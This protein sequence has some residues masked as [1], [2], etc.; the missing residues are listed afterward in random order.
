MTTMARFL[1]LPIEVIEIILDHLFGERAAPT[2]H[3]GRP[4]A[5]R[6][7]WRKPL[8]NLALI[9]QRLAPL[10]RGR[11]Y[12]HSEFPLGLLVCSEPSI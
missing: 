10:V 1:D 9:C 11:V 8:T 5:L 7:P 12:R 4:S 2:F 3:R 6:H